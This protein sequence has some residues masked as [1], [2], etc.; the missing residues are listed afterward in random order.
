M[1][2]IVE[3]ALV[4]FYAAAAALAPTL[5]PGALAQIHRRS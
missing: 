5:L 4:R 1:I 2:G 3:G